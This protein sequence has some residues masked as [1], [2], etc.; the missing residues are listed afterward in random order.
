MKTSHKTLS[1]LLGFAVIYSSL[2]VMGFGLRFNSSNSLPFYAFY[3]F[4]S[5]EA[6]R[7]MYVAI[8]HPASEIKLAKQI[9]GIAG[10]EINIDGD[11]IKVKGE[12]LGIILK[13]GRSGQTLTPIK[14]GII[15]KGH[16]FVYASHPQSFDSRYEDFG[17]ISVDQI[18]E[19]LW[20][21]F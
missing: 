14:E 15:P 9:K 10:D 11:F 3:S 13:T 18:V 21:I 20:P 2:E 19:V 8:K 12:T 5:K 16:V 1:L 17:L 7:D 6:K 4:K